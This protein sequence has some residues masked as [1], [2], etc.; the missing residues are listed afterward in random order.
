VVPQKN[1]D[2]ELFSISD[3]PYGWRAQLALEFK[4]LKYTPRFLSASEGENRS[5]AFLAL[6]PRGKVPVLKHGKLVVYESLAVMA[7]LES[8]FPDPPLFGGSSALTGHV[9]Q[10]LSEFGSYADVPIRSIILPLYFGV[11][12]AR[13]DEIRRALPSVHEELAFLEQAL[14]NHRWLVDESLSAADLGIYPFIKSL[15]R[16]AGKDATNA[17]DLELLP[18]SK[19][20][21]ALGAWTKRIETLPYY[22]RTYPPHW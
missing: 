20:Y 18:V 16:A 14:T 10:R 3:S 19:R 9:W 15:E 13:A 5:A 12:D 8:R 22:R 11:A 6:N 2:I 1:I 4:G 17:F 21:P 7:Y